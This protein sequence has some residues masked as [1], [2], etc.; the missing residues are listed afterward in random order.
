V[1]DGRSLRVPGHESGYF[2]GACLFDHVTPAMKIYRDEI[3]G[4]VLAVVRVTSL[5]AA[6]ELI[7]AHEY[8]NGTCI[9]TR[10]GEAARYFCDH[11]KIGMVGVNIPLPVP[12]AYHSFGGWKR[13]FFGDL[14]AYGPD[15]VRFYTRRKTIT[16]RWPSAGLREGAVYNFPSQ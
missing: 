7:D 10:D 2:L 16:Q 14:G 4:P 5:K 8:G 1:V 3:F 11:I 13:S 15:G 6:M 9:F 12:V